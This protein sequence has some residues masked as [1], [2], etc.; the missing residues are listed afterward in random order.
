[1][2]F[3]N[4]NHIECYAKTRQE[5]L[6]REAEVYRLLYADKP[7]R[8]PTYGRI[9]VIIGNTLIVIGTKLKARYETVNEAVNTGTPEPAQG[10]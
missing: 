2:M 4:Y 8:Q 3:N 9:V 6:M 10:Y 7:S 5:D 1:M